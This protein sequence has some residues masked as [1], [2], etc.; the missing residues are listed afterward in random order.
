MDSEALLGQLPD[1]YIVQ[2]HNADGRS[3]PRY[4]RS[5]IG[6]ATKEDPRLDPLDQHWQRADREVT[7]DDPEH[8]D[9]FRNEHTGELINYDP[10]L[11]KTAL[12]QRGANLQN[13]T[14]V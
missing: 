1:H 5:D 2:Q 12:E 7:A 6:E 10:R 11:S 8:V 4:Y 3:L 9:F 14:L 13:I